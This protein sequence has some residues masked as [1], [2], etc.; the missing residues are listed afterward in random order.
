M[1]LKRHKNTRGKQLKKK[2]SMVGKNISTGAS[3]ADYVRMWDFVWFYGCVASVCWI[4]I[5]SFVA[6]LLKQ[7]GKI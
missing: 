1:S 6:L 3:R 4:G 7:G 5:I 2:G